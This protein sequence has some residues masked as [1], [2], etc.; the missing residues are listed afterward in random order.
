[1]RY[2]HLLRGESDFSAHSSDDELADE[3]LLS[4]TSPV[5]FIITKDALREGWDCP[6]AYVLAV[7]S[8]TTATTVLT[9]MIGIF[10]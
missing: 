9:Q 8:R 10:G 1:M 2:L 6:F 5:R 7:L 4:D 3:D